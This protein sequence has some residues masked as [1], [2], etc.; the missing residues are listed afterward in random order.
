MLSHR[1]NTVD[2]VIALLHNPPLLF[3]LGVIMIV[4]GLALVLGHNLWSGGAATV[5]VTVTSWIVLLK[6]AMLLFVSPEAE[7]S[8][9]LGTLHYEQFFYFYSSITL[10]LGL[11]L[12]YAAS[13][14]Q[15]PKR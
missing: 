13:G 6:G 12:T 11:Y 8:L 4:A 1:Q 9:F 7:S 10:V 14:R 15:A 3:L 5:A 2:V